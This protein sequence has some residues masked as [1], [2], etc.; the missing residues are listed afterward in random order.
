[1]K[2]KIFLTLSVVMLLF[3]AC[4]EDAL[5]KSN[6]NQLST[7]TFFESAAQMEAATNAAYTSMQTP[8]FYNRY[9]FFMNDLMAQECFGMGSLGSD[10]RQY[11]DYSFDG[12]NPGFQAFWNVNYQGISRAN[13]VI[14][15][16]NTVPEEA[17][18]ETLRKRY[19]G[20]AKFMRAFYYFE[21]VSRFGDIPLYTEV[22]TVPIGNPRTAASE[23]YDLIFDDL[24]YAETNLPQKSTYA[25][26]DLG[27]A[28]KTAAQALKGKIRLFRGE[29]SEALTELQKVIDSGEH[30]LQDDFY[31]NFTEEGEHNSESIFEVQYNSTFGGGGAWGGDGSGVSEVTFRGQEYG[32]SAWRNVIP[33][34]ELLAE[35]EE[36]DPRYDMS[37]YFPGDTY[38]PND[39]FVIEGNVTIPDE[40]G[41]WRKY[42]RYYKQEREDTN[43]GVNFRI[44][45]YA[46]VLLM[47]AEAKAQT[48]DVAG[49]VT[50]MN[51]IRSRANVDMPLYG[52]AE[53][54]AAGY[55]VSTLDGFMDA[56]IHERAVELCGEQIRY[57][58]LKRWG[59]LPEVVPNYSA[60]KHELLPIPSHEIDANENISQADQNPGY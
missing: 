22:A 18:S 5:D 51:M 29:Y 42:Q 38:G 12:S 1:M 48:G 55:P 4:D 57:R 25:S 30:S 15:N 39:E 45:R 11:I 34:D 24:D 47:A 53:M 36:G 49:G 20:E 44:I 46:D 31:D 41:S 21:L 52:S 54:D 9:Y 59:L 40:L 28:T 60:N 43:S 19:V 3:G 37:F 7:S 56:L 16:E 13:L 32:F 14:Q 2:R 10:L 50:L 8:G 17:I 58:D 35:F 26:A 33:S 6:P 27:R 23:I